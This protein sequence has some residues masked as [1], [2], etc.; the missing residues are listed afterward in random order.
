MTAFLGMTTADV[1]DHA[2]RLTREAEVLDSLLQSL[3]QGVDG[4]VGT[5]WRGTDAERF[6]EDFRGATRP[7]VAAAIAALRG[8]A[9]E[10]ERHVEEQETASAPEADGGS[11]FPAGPITGSA[12][13]TTSFLGADWGDASFGEFW[14]NWTENVGIDGADSAGGIISGVH[15]FAKNFGDFAF[16]KGS[17]PGFIPVIGDVFTGVMAGVDRWNDDAGDP[18]L[19]TGERI[20]RAVL[21]GGANL[22]G[23]LGG[24]LVGGAIGTS[25]GGSIGGLFGGGGGAAAGAPAAGVGAVPGAVVG[26]GG[27]AAV[28]GVIGGI[29]GDVVG[30]YFGATTADAVIDTFL[31]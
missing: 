4:V 3:D 10:L 28:G 27:G 6:A 11:A 17:V 19:S 7:R 13:L 20:G 22:I 12:P 16:G 1:A 30:S 26:G 21:D 14:D 15:S 2:A 31:D 18:G 5:H 25:I 23:S 24:S 9:A 8:H 29:A